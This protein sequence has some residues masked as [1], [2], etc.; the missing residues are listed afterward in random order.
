MKSFIAVAAKVMTVAA[1]L[2]L[3]VPLCLVGTA[4]AAL[5][6][7]GIAALMGLACTAVIILVV[8]D[9]LCFDSI[10]SLLTKVIEVKP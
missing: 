2:V 8:I 5:V 4:L 7:G 6:A 10:K 1:L 9:S 3:L